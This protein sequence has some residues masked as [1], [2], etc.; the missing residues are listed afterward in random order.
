MIYQFRNRVYDFSKRT[1]IVGIV[2][3]TPDSFSDGG[4][5]FSEDAA[6]GQAMRLAEAGAD[7][8]DIGGESTRPGAEAV[9]AEEELRRVLPVIKSLRRLCELPLSID[10]YKPEV[11]R[12]ALAAGAVIVNDITSLTQNPAMAHVAA[13]FGASLVLMHMQGSPRTMQVNPHYEN[14]I[15]D[16]CGY[17]EKGIARAQHAGVRQIIVDPGIG[18]GKTLED[19]LIIIRHLSEFGRFG[20]P[21]MVGPSRKSFIG[22]ILNLPVD[23]R[24]EGTAAVVAASIFY[25]AHIVRVHDVLEIKRVATMVD[26]LVHANVDSILQNH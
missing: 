25:G 14:L 4:K 6:I 24:M 9:D 15:E 7:I 5:W 23:Q 16:I 21:V 26:A 11:A 17:L 13:E 22:K 1:H 19:N 3:V 12:E 2:N 8:L 10:T 18:F 20:F